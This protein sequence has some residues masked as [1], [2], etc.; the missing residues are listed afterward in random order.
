MKGVGKQQEHTRAAQIK[1][2]GGEPLFPDIGYAAYLIS[3]WRDIGICN[4]GAMGPVP[5]TCHD[6]NAWQTGVG[7]EL[8]AWEFSTILDLSRAYLA[9]ARESEKLECPPPFGG[10]V[11]EF[12]REA[13]RKK[14]TTAFKTSIKASKHGR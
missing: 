5:L 2:R 3:Y 12:D 6:L 10:V 7:V 9:Q 11:T 8:E 4:S 13:V 1:S 14:I